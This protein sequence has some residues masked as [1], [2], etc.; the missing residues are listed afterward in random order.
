MGAERLAISVEIHH[1][2]YAEALEERR[3]RYNVVKSSKRWVFLT[4]YLPSPVAEATARFLQKN[5]LPEMFLEYLDSVYEDIPEEDRREIFQA[6]LDYI[7]GTTFTRGTQA[8]IQPSL[9]ESKG[10]SIQGWLQF[11]G[12][13]LFKDLVAQLAYEGLRAMR[14]QRAYI[15]FKGLKD[16]SHEHLIIEG[17]GEKLVIKNPSGIEMFREFLQGYLDPRLKIDQEDL[18]CSLIRALSPARVDLVNVSPEFRKRITEI[19]RS[20]RSSEGS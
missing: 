3:L 18:A 2:G 11:R 9:E 19:L 6:N 5:I 12:N 1:P 8:L 17:R 20:H 14:L 10:I 16:H 7:L 15:Q 13:S 4:D